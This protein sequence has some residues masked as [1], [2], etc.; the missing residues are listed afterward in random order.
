MISYILDELNELI[1]QNTIEIKE[2]LKILR[3]F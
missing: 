1:T 2:N 3:S